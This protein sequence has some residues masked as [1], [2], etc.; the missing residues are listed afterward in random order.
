[1]NPALVDIPSSTQP[2]TR[3]VDRASSAARPPRIGVWGHYHGANLGDELLVST[4]I[5]NI[6]TRLPHA[7]IIGFC[8][9][10]VDTRLRHGIPAFPTYRFAEQI[11]EPTPPW[12]QDDAVAPRRPAG[13]L[14]RL[15]SRVKRHRWLVGPLRTMRSV[16]RAV[17]SPFIRFVKEF[18]FLVRSY[19]RLRGIDMLVVAGSGP[20]YDGSGTWEHPY[21]VFKWAALARLRGA[22]FACL[23]V[24]AGP[25]RSSLSRV[26]LAGAVRMTSYRSYRDPSSARLI[27]S[28]RV[29][30]DHPVVTDLGFGFDAERHVAACPLPETGDK[31]VVALCPMAHGDPRY[32]RPGDPHRYEAYLGKMV[33]LCAALLQDDQV[34][35][36]FSSDR[37]DARVIADLRERLERERGLGAHPRLM[38][39]SVYGLSSLVSAFARCHY[40]IAARYHCVVIPWLLGIPVVGLAYNQKTIDLMASMGQAEHCLDIDRFG[41]AEAL[42]AGHSV[43]RHGDAIRQ[44]LRAGVAARRALLA[45][46][47]DRLLRGFQEPSPRTNGHARIAGDVR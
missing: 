46:Q 28:L 30:G 6:R 27:G 16:L 7:E 33:E 15:A 26:F 10:P 34:V 25:I 37:A 31:T 9:N 2:E 8:Q 17:V 41:V 29:R 12:D 40:V 44:S 13:L 22:R 43:L 5:E 21:A 1:M 19:R 42:H 18:G 39:P 45:E 23:S 38:Q 32:V 4:L 11:T 36:L 47:Y 3:R 20:L 35:L 24:G 14:G